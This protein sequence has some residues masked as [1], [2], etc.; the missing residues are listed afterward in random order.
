[1]LLRVLVIGLIIHMFLTLSNDL[2]SR[3]LDE[4]IRLVP[5]GCDPH[6]KVRRSNSADDLKNS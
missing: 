4:I 3:E 1:M 5:E 2:L 6:A